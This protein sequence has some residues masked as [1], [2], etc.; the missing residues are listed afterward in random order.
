MTQMTTNK[1]STYLAI[2]F[3]LFLG[4]SLSEVFAQSYEIKTLKIGKGSEQ[5]FATDY[6]NG[7]LYFCSNAK[8]KQ[9]KNVVNEDNTRFLN[10][11][12]IELD[13]Q[14]LSLIHI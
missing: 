4:S 12:N 5:V 1:P 14:L 9:A 8:A 7:H 11:Y 13:E 2:F 6:Y 3:L 10:L